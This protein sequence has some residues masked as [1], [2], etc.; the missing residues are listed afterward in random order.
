MV[1]RMPAR[2]EPSGTHE[3]AS[4]RAG[5]NAPFTIG[6][7]RVHSTDRARLTL[8]AMAFATLSACST[9][10]YYG[11]LAHGE[12]AMLAARRP[13]DRIVADPS[14]DAALKERLQLAERAR[15][16]ASDRLQLPRNASYTL[17]A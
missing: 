10:G 2:G 7:M 3:H 6:A 17:Y 4:R 11:H 15:A 9:L 12:Y 5:D 14:V 8:G 1:P 13:I 16:F